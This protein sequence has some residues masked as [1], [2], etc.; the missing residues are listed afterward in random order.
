MPQQGI[1]IGFVSGKG[2]TGKTSLVA[3]IG[4]ALAETGKRTLCVDCDTEFRNLD[5]VMGLTEQSLMDFTDVAAGRCTLEE[6]VTEHP[7]RRGLFLL[8]API[9]GGE[10]VTK[11]EMNALAAHIRKHFD[12]CLM[13]APPGMGDSFGLVSGAA[14]RMLL[15]AEMN[16]LSVRDAQRVVT[17]L[18]AF[19]PGDVRL[20]VNRVCLSPFRRPELTIDDIMDGAGLPLAGL[21]PEDDAVLKALCHGTLIKPDSAA[22]RACRNIAQ[23]IGGEYVPLPRMYR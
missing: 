2:G 17:E 22:G 15:V 5:L 4:A 14:D 6:A 11:M 13:D 19:P 18:D 16:P 12:F 9:R 10:R 20:I 1:C 7:A 3:G 21:V 8:N 23:R